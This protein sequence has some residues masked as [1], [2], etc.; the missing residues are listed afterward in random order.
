M[1]LSV[2][3]SA[4]YLKKWWP[5]FDDILKDKCLYVWD[6]SINFWR[7]SR[8]ICESAIIF[9]DSWPVNIGCKLTFCSISTTYVQNLMKYTGNIGN[10][11]G[12]WILRTQSRLQ[13][14]SS[15]LN[16]D[17][18]PVWDFLLHYLRRRRLFSL[19]SVCLSVCPSDNWKSCER[20]LLKFLGG[21]RA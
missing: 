12:Y 20:I 5:G 11:V 7:G 9:Q 21:G 4:K 2:F 18:H 19:R 13:P 15:I 3:E 6:K 14:W 1:C 17:P 16:N 10:M 8:F